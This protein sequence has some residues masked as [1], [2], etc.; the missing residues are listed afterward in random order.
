[1]VNWYLNSAGILGIVLALG[2]L[3]LYVLR[4]MRP[5]LS[6]DYDIFFAAVGLLSGGI[7][8]FQGWRFDPIMQFSQFLLTGSAIFFAFETIRLRGIATEQARRNTPIVDED[9]PVSKVYRAE[10]DRMEP[11]EA[12]DD[13]YE[14]RRLRGYQERT[15]SRSSTY[16]EEGSRPRKSRRPNDRYPRESTPTRA[17][18]SSTVSRPVYDQWGEPIDQWDDRPRRDESPRDTD[19]EHRPPSRKKR[20]PSSTESPARPRRSAESTD[21]VDYQPI[22]NLGLDNEVN[23]ESQ[24]QDN[25]DYTGDYTKEYP[26]D[27]RP[28]SED[29]LGRFDY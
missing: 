16:E 20:R 17:P 6:R 15:S 8:F 13:D 9:R 5:E 18:R 1:M 22:D 4:S 27:D 14:R 25:R 7:L 28:P 2:G 26:K 11:Y 10:L 12:E 21:Y 24:E 3:G 23:N 19:Y 29:S